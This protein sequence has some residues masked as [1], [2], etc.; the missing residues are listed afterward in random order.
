MTLI[1]A[2][3]YET[4]EVVSH[5]VIESSKKATPGVHVVFRQHWEGGSWSDIAAD[6]WLS[7]GAIDRSFDALEALGWFGQDVA[8]LN[9]GAVVL[10]GDGCSI[11]VEHEEYEGK[12]RAR[13]AWVNKQGSM[14][15]AHAVDDAGMA[16]VRAQTAGRL[17]ARRQQQSTP[18]ELPA[19]AAATTA[20]QPPPPP[21]PPPPAIAPPAATGDAPW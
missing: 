2:G 13:V 12:A 18:P 21:P 5:C 16:R 1:P 8:E 19:R 17:A 15:G 9:T 7:D 4:P 6:L 3:T 14:P 20:S 11:T 10:R